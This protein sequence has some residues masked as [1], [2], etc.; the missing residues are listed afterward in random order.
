M[1]VPGVDFVELQIH[2]VGE[3]SDGSGAALAHSYSVS[4]GSSMEGSSPPPQLRDDITST[5]REFMEA[6]QGKLLLFQG[7]I[8]AVVQGV[9]R[10]THGDTDAWRTEAQVREE[11]DCRIEIMCL[12][13]Q[14]ASAADFADLREELRAQA[15][16]LGELWQHMGMGNE[17][18]DRTQARQLFPLQDKFESLDAHMDIGTITGDSLLDGTMLTTRGQLHQT[19]PSATIKHE[20]QGPMVVQSYLLPAQAPAMPVSTPKDSGD[21]ATVVSLRSPSR[22]F[23]PQTVRGSGHTSLLQQAPPGRVVQGLASS[24]DQLPRMPSWVPA[25][26]LL[27]GTQ[28]AQHP[29]AAPSSPGAVVSMVHHQSLVPPLTLC[30]TVG[31][32]SRAVDEKQPRL[33]SL[34]SQPL[35]ASARTADDKSPRPAAGSPRRLGG[36]FRPVGGQFQAVTS[37][38]APT[39]GAGDSAARTPTAALRVDTPPPRFSAPRRGA[40]AEPGDSGPGRR[41]ARPKESTSWVPAAHAVPPFPLCFARHP[42]QGGVVAS[43]RSRA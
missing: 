42:P 12:R 21:G 33:T 7:Q 14:E 36:S 2:D 4:K 6:V 15:S 27:L 38:V 10:L 25:S 39:A 30:A 13:M 31:S 24:S 3:L 40:R 35:S 34:P 5:M 43:P 29:A 26:P 17:G 28:R 20:H 41:V 1:S 18:R 8:D 19:M 22:T 16:E 32:P 37:V 23:P 11:E 9:E